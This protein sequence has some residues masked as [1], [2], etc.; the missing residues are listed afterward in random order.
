MLDREGL[1]EGSNPRNRGSSSRPSHRQVRRYT[2]GRNGMWVLPAGNGPD[3]F[4]EEKAPKGKSQERCRC[5]TKPARVTKG[6]NR[7]EGNQT[8]RAERSGQAKV[9]DQW[10]FEPGPVLFRT[11]SA[12]G[13]YPSELSPRQRCPLRFHRDGPT[14]RLSFRIYHPAEA[15]WP[16][17]ESRGFWVSTLPASPSRTHV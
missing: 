6:V 7:R 12:P 3:T 11:G 5:E 15:G 17:P 16:A 2:D 1:S 4:C 8:L 14:Y 9:R 10:T 13:L